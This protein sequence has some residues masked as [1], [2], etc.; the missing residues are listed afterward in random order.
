M[1]R[2]PDPTPPDGPD[3]YG[4]PEPD[5]LDID[6]GPHLSSVDVAGTTVNY[7]ELGEGPP[8]VF[9]HGLAGCW[10]NWL[11]NVSHFGGQGYRAI[12]LDLP[13]FA[14]SP[15]PPWPITVPAYSD[16]LEE[17]CAALELGDEVAVVGNSMGGYVAADLATRRPSWLKRLA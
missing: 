15:M 17:F 10:Q 14:G 13:G 16:L 5:W 2:A 9:V 1:R 11:E 3:P 7:A 6:W 12:A 4:N 8:I